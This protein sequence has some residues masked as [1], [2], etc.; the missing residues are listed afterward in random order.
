MSAS[1][2]ATIGA[3]VTNTSASIRNYVINLDRSKD[4]LDTFQA[5][6]AE[7]G[8]VFQRVPAVEGAA[9]SD[10]EFDAWHAKCRLCVPMTRTEV[11]CF[12]SHR[13]AW[14]LVQASA[15]PWAFVTEDDIVFAPGAEQFFSSVSWLPANMDVVKAETMGD[16]VE[17]SRKVYARH[18]GAVVRLLKSRHKGAAGYFL[19]REGARRLLNSP[20]RVVKLWTRCSLI[21]TSQE[22]PISRSV[23]SSRP[24]VCRTS[25]SFHQRSN[26]RPSIL[27]AAFRAKQSGDACA[28]R[29]ACLH[30]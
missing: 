13:K 30:A 10:S 12:L 20:K 21:R 18:C 1:A 26:V 9:I 5:R 15:D 24:C 11:A 27:S 3:M 22:V 25:T 16:K 14:S 28:R 8:L 19:S 2:F 23:R 4:R 29:K 6:A 7:R 17:M